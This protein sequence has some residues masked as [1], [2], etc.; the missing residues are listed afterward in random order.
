MDLTQQNL[1]T[2]ASFRLHNVSVEQRVIADR[3]VGER[4]HF[5]NGMWWHRVKPCFYLPA[6]FLLPLRP[7]VSPPS[8][9]RALGGYY[10]V[11]P[12]GAPANGSI[13]T[14]EIADPGTF[15]LEMLKKNKNG[16]RKV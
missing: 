2:I 14:N 8:A 4:F 5:S 9:W 6:S 13:V 3:Q 10:H 11:V 1:E 15:E 16:A 12:D 7:H